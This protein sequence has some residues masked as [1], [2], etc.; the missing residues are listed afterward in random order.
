MG[1]ITYPVLFNGTDLN[2]VPGLTVLATN[3]YHPPRRD[4]NSSNVA[5]TNKG[6]INS[7]FYVERLI[8][9]RIEISR[10]S[11]A[12]MEASL[13]SLNA[14]LQP[15]EKALTLP[16]SGTLRTYCVTF[17]DFEADEDTE[18][19]MYL[20]GNL[21]F[22]C[23]DRY[24]YDLAATQLLAFTGF[25]SQSRSDALSF[26]GSAEWQCPV[27]TITFTSVTTGTNKSVIIG[28]DNTGQAL[29]ITRTFA[30]NDVLVIDTLNRTVKVNGTE[31]VFTGAI[32]EW[33][34]GT[35]YWSYRDTLGGRTIT[36]M[37]TVVRRYV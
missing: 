16:Q 27:I 13:D 18:G 33:N 30:S 22:T 29:T 37:L 4:V 28:N 24:G 2:T 17:S 12:L 9:V 8:M 36:A 34:V 3:P 32:P 10:N 5:R 21:I 25:T 19:G 35:G 15:K 6:K 14:L 23:S 7:A 20:R 1:K 26:G 31:V 11:R